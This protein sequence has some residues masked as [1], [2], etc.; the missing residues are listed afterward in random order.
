M[1]VSRELELKLVRPSAKWRGEGPTLR[2]NYLM[3]TFSCTVQYCTVQFLTLLGPG[4]FTQPDETPEKYLNGTPDILFRPDNNHN[5]LAYG[6]DLTRP[7]STA[8]GLVSVWVTALQYECLWCLSDGSFLGLVPLVRRSVESGSLALH[9]MS[10]FVTFLK[11]L[12]SSIVT[13][14][15]KEPCS[16]LNTRL[17]GFALKNWC[18]NVSSESVTLP[19]SITGDGQSVIDCWPISWPAMVAKMKTLISF[20]W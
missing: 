4:P 6:I 10:K 7:L 9:L 11:L 15:D 20:I 17:D 14:S 8:V 18:V 5:T 16:F 19:Q 12:F 1:V 3:I 2:V 13:P